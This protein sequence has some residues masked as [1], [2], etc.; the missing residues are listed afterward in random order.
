MGL[1]LS[2]SAE[3]DEFEEDFEPVAYQDGPHR[4]SFISE[5]TNMKSTVFQSQIDATALMASSSTKHKTK[6]SP[7]GPKTVPALGAFGGAKQP[8]NKKANRFLSLRL[9]SPT[10]NLIM[11]EYDVIERNK[12]K[13]LKKF[14]KVANELSPGL[15]VSGEYPASNMDLLTSLGVTD[16]INLAGK[17]VPNA[18]PHVFRYLTVDTLDDSISA[19]VSKYFIPGVLEIHSLLTQGRSAKTVKP[20]VCQESQRTTPYQAEVKRRVLLHCSQGV[21]RSCSLAIAYMMFRARLH[22]E[23]CSYQTALSKARDVRGIC[24]PNAGF[25]MQLKQWEYLLTMPSPLDSP[26]ASRD[27]GDEDVLLRV[28]QAGKAL[29]VALLCRGE[30]KDFVPESAPVLLVTAGQVLVNRQGSHHDLRKYVD[31]I[32]SFI[33]SLYPGFEVVYT[34]ETPESM[35][36]LF[37]SDSK[38]SSPEHTTTTTSPQ[39]QS[40]DD[41]HEEVVV[42]PRQEVE[43]VEHR[44]IFSDS[45][46]DG[47]PFDHTMVSLWEVEAGRYAYSGI[48]DK[49][50]IVKFDWDDLWDT[51]AY[52]IWARHPEKTATE[53][54]LVFV[55]AGATFVEQQ[56]S[57]DSWNDWAEQSATTFL[58]SE[59][60]LGAVRELQL[61]LSRPPTVLLEMEGHETELFEQAVNAGA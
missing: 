2:R 4:V 47:V 48:S 38:T 45:D 31:S 32:A 28:E 60:A 30:K 1:C 50:M 51:K 49:K 35:Q 44:M 21:S 27:R 59:V 20:W 29:N 5:T 11:A 58:A 36:P 26:R 53:P 8:S 25:I 18:F 24:R 19:D 46:D 6:T 40:E 42:G 13:K 16:V 43:R 57:V 41:E 7:A 54:D 23:D 17:S 9:P 3:R 33:T 52:I 39:Q 34:N 61:P 55:W 14:R 15:F 12:S 37:P 10:A 22:D 56:G